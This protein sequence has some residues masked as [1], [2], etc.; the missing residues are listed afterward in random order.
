MW[1]IF[2]FLF[3]LQTST[4]FIY[5]DTASG[6]PASLSFLCVY[7]F[8]PSL[9]EGVL[10][11]C[12]PVALWLSGSWH[13]CGGS[14]GLCSAWYIRG[15]DKRMV[16]ARRVKIFGFFT[17]WN[18]LQFRLLW[19]QG[20]GKCVCVCACTVRVKSAEVKAKLK[21]YLSAENERIWSKK[22]RGGKAWNR[23]KEKGPL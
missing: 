23:K 7:V 8:I 11:F 12:A 21:S 4:N 1:F 15:S 19:G 2:Y 16:S 18:T 10:P 9:I 22:K 13:V 14:W 5:G 20:H 3:H 17:A 6:L